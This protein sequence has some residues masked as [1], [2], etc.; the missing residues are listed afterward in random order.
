MI[1]QKTSPSNEGTTVRPKHKRKSPYRGIH[2]CPWGKWAAE[3]RDPR[4]GVR[5]WLGTYRTPEDAA[6]AYDAEAHKIRGNKAKVNFSDEAP[7]NILSNTLKPTI[8]AMATM[9]VP[10]EKFNTNELVRHTNN[11]NGDLFSV[12]NFS[13]NNGIL[14][15]TEAFV[16][17]SMEK[18]DV[19][20]YEIPWMG[21]Y[22]TQNRFA[23]GSSNALVNEVNTNLNACSFLPLAGMAMSNQPTFG[24]SSWMIEMM[25]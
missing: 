1:K 18:P 7:P 11:S 22:S 13:G 14:A 6:R 3:I 15:S 10:V 21:E 17:H 5:V 4:K 16:L 9:I 25:V 24:G 20:P 23:F 12:V 19:V 8:T 2:R